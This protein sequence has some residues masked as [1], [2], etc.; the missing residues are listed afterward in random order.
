RAAAEADMLTVIDQLT[1]GWIAERSGSA[2]QLTPSLEKFDSNSAPCQGDGC[3]PTGQAAAHDRHARRGRNLSRAHKAAVSQLEA[4][5][6]SVRRSKNAPAAIRS[7]SP[8]LSRI[9]R[10]SA[11]YGRCRIFA[12]SL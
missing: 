6:L 4:S 9:L 12:R 3:R 1:A 5:R 10:R 11:S 2:T 8:A 7:F